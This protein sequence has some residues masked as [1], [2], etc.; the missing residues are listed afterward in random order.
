MGQVMS[1]PP[2]PPGPPGPAGKDSK[3]AGPP[4]PPGPA[5]QDST[6][7]GPPGPAG[8]AGKDGQNGQNGE[9][10][11]KD[12]QQKSMWCADGTLCKVPNNSYIE[13]QIGN[14]IA[15]KRTGGYGCQEAWDGITENL[16]WRAGVTEDKYLS[17]YWKGT[18]GKL[19]GVRIEGVEAN[20]NENNC[21]W[22]RL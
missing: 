5:G 16:Q 20:P 6:I 13:G 12:L 18:D 9:V 10:T 8:P 17:I 2:G 4:G 3:I 1:G 11:F 19:Y 7:A 15:S 14:F 22:K 21:V